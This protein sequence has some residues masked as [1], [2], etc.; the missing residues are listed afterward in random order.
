MIVVADAI[1]MADLRRTRAA[2][3]P[4]IA[5]VIGGVGEGAAVGLRAGEDVVLDGRQV[6]HRRG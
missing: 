3:G 6:A 4:I 5:R 2:A 1:G